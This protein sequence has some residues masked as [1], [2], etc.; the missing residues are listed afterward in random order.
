MAKDLSS[1][2]VD[3]RHRLWTFIVYPDSAPP[4]WREMLDEKH[5]TWVESP[6]HDADLNADNT[7][8]K[9]H[10]HIALIFDGKKSYSQIVEITLSLNSPIPQT[11][12]SLPA[13]IRYF[14]HLDNPEKH[15]Y[16]PSLIIGHGGADVA[17]LLK[18]TC[19][20]RYLYISEMQDWCKEFGCIEFADL[21]DY[22][23]NNRFND[24][25]PLLC[26]S[27]AFVMGQY[28]KSARNIAISKNGGD[29][30]DI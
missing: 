13:L 10:I 19:S 3:S 2:K 30:N 23:R 5:L 1:G 26:D 28:L 14:A 11:V 18:P 25:Y 9:P 12:A 22:A 21:L 6:L 16:D 8:K 20:Q 17:N 27:C 29:T 7:Q 24:W 15:Q 4:N